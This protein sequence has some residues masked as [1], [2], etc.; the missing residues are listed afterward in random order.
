MSTALIPAGDAAIEGVVMMTRAEAEAAERSIITGIDNLRE[1]IATFDDQQGWA[2][3]GWESFRAWASSRIP[4]ANLRYLYRLRDANQ[5]DKLLGAPVGATPE[6]HAREV[7]NVAPDRVPD[8]FRRADRIAAEQG[9]D[10]QARDVAAAKQQVLGT[11]AAPKLKPGQEAPIVPEVLVIGERTSYYTPPPLIRESVQYAT[12]TT[13]RTAGGTR[14]KHQVYCLPDDAAFARIADAVNAFGATLTDLAGELRRLGSYAKRLDEAGGMKSAPNPL[15]ETVANIDDPDQ[16][17]SRWWMQPWYVPRMQREP[18]ARHT[19]KMLS[20]YDADHPN[21]YVFAQSNCF[22]LP[23][24][25][26]WEC[27]H[28]RREAV[29]DAV[30]HVDRVLQELGLYSIAQADGRY[31]NRPAAAPSTPAPAYEPN[32]WEAPAAVAA[33]ERLA[34]LGY[35]LD[36][37][38]GAWRANGA[39][40]GAWSDV[41]NFLALVESKEARNDEDDAID[42]ELHEE[43]WSHEDAAS[44]AAI[45]LAR[46]MMTALPPLYQR[47][48]AAAVSIEWLDVDTLLDQDSTRL[49]A[50]ATEQLAIALHALHGER[51]DSWL[52]DLINTPAAP[53][54]VDAPA[55]GS[56]FALSYQALHELETSLDI[57]GDPKDCNFAQVRVWAATLLM[58]ARRPGLTEEPDRE[59]V[60]ELRDRLE[61]LS[62]LDGIDD[63]EWEQLNRDLEQIE[64]MMQ[65]EATDGR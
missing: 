2:A 56:L 52:A 35:T 1:Q 30:A 6:S 45:A 50:D 29:K 64:R 34:R 23:D 10:R 43:N 17:G 14:Q 27:L 61:D 8:V 40:I 22:V 31:R 18:I 44:P 39:V 28:E 53:V 7:K 15:C 55:R 36:Y 46:R 63:A 19:P 41:Q 20:K 21:A 3:L 5:V 59:I 60:R 24:D 37:N 26:A 16:D 51:S 48:L 11:P 65:E 49:I 58:V 38:D 54:A 13:V 32:P 33:R 4:D 12:P 25:A 9:R 62:D 57:W 47:A 42:P